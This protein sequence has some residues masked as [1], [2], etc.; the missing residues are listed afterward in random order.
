MIRRAA[1]LAV[2]GLVSG[3]LLATGPHEPGPLASASAAVVSVFPAW[4]LT[5]LFARH[6]RGR[7]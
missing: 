7:L 2:A 3:V 4:A 1:F 5:G 6:G